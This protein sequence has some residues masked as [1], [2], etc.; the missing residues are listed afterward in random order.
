MQ[1]HLKTSAFNTRATELYWFI[2]Y[3]VYMYVLE[4][5]HFGRFMLIKCCL[6]L[7][8]HISIVIKRHT[9]WPCNKPAMRH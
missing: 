3:I 1:K 9:M 4:P 5:L 7:E 6:L 2:L 8:K